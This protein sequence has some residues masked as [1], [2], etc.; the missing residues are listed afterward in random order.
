MRAKQP[1][2][3][4]IMP[5]HT[6]APRK[7]HSP[8]GVAGLAVA[9]MLCMTAPAAFS[10][11]Y[12]QKIVSQLRTQGYQQI[13]TERT[14][15]GRVRIVALQNG[16]QREIVLN[17]RTGEVL[18]DAWFFGPLEKQPEARSVGA[19]G[20]A[21]S[22]RSGDDDTGKGRDDDDDDDDEKDEKDDDKDSDD[23]DDDGDDDD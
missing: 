15:L 23:K 9:V 4:W 5:N 16:T 18:R 21:R 17:P 8:N 2:G 13:M 14:L 6:L 10:Q 19:G 20:S 11:T 3:I 12:E 22:S 7:K 1:L